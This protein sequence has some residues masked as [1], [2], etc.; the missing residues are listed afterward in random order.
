ME[1]LGLTMTRPLT[2]DGGTTVASPR[3][4]A[5][6]HTSPTWSARPVGSA[7][8]VGREAGWSQT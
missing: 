8:R 7:P 1:T 2:G 3:P 6:G 4:V 5:A